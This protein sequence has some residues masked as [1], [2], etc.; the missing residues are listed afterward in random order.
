MFGNSTTQATHATLSPKA[1]NAWRLLKYTYGIVPIAA[2]LDK[3]FN[4]LTNWSLYI[5]PALPKLVSLEPTQ[6]MYIVGAIEIAAGIL[7]LSNYTKFGAYLVSFW[8]LFIAAN[9]VSTGLFYDVAVRDTVMA[10]GALALA[11]LSSDMPCT[12]KACGYN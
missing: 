10:I 7:V 8:L 6:F 11:I 2:G 5:N 9:L 12:D 3:Y 4:I 1:Y